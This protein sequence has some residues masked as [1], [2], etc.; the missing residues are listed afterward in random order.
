MRN[1]A[2]LVWKGFTSKVPI[3]LNSTLQLNFQNIII[4]FP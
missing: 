2:Q 3:C 4:Y 1:I